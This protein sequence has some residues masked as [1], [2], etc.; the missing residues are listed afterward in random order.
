M[1]DRHTP[2][3]MRETVLDLISGEFYVPM[4]MRDMTDVLTLE[5][6][7]Y[8]LFAA[9]IEELEREGELAFTK[10]GKIARAENSGLITCVYRA[11]TRGFGFASTEK[12]DI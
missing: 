9:V 12:E 8:D 2:E 10:K 11:T 7:D 5:P 1:T 6:G 3:A 4:D